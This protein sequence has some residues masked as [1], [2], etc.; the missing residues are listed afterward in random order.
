M[1]TTLYKLMKLDKRFVSPCGFF[2]VSIWFTPKANEL[3]LIPPAPI[4]RRPKEEYKIKS[5]DAAGFV[6]L[7]LNWSQKGLACG[8]MVVNHSKTVPCYIVNSK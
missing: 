7:K 3:D 6:H 8:M 2:V 1:T 5:W 4:D